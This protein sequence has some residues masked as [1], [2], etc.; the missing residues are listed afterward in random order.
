MRTQFAGAGGDGGGDG[1][2]GEGERRVCRDEEHELKNISTSLSPESCPA[3]MVRVQL[4]CE[5]VEQRGQSSRA[6]GCGTC[7]ARLR[8]RAMEPLSRSLNRVAPAAA[9]H[10]G[11]LHLS[12]VHMYCSD[13]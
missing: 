1:G 12:S 2:G 4:A 3:A 13:T 10:Y 6:A 5:G 9:L 11:T 8:D 7:G